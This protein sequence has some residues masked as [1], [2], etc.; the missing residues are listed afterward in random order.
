MVRKAKKNESLLALDE[1]TYTFSGE[2]LVIADESL[3][4]AV[5]GVIGGEESAV[6][7]H[8]TAIVFECANF[9]NISVRK[10]ARA[11]SLQ[12]D[13]SSLFEKGLHPVAT[14]LA[15]LR[16]IE[17]ARELAGGKVASEI[18]DQQHFTFEPTVIRLDVE[19]VSE[20]LGERVTKDVVVRSLRGLGFEVEGEEL[21]LDV[22]VPWWRAQDV[23]IGQDLIEE[24]ARL[25]GYANLP[26]VLPVGSIPTP[27]L[28]RTLAW[29]DRVKDL[30]LA[31]GGTELYSYSL[32]SSKLL[33]A[34][35]FDSKQCL[36]VANPLSEE[37]QYL[38]PTLL[39]SLL[40]AVGGNQRF[41]PHQQLFELSNV[42][43]PLHDRQ[44]PEERP[45]LTV[46]IAGEAEESFFKAKG[47]AETLLQR[48]GISEVKFTPSKTHCPVWE[49]AVSLDMYVGQDFLGT[50][51]VVST[52]TRSAFGLDRA[53]AMVDIN[54]PQLVKHARSV[55]SYAPIPEFPAV[56]R[57]IAI[58]IDKNV[59]WEEIQNVIVSQAEKQ[60]GISVQL[61]FLSA[62]ADT[63]LG[64]NKKSYAF[65]VT[66]QPAQRTLTSAEIEQIIGK[67]TDALQKK[68][69]A[70]PR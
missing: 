37:Y 27:P 41:F 29:E 3:P 47:V 21:E 48:C 52:A 53:V 22:R 35:G 25:Y 69:N 32:V 51:G 13:S 61:V 60:S 38:R 54:F 17:L 64:E 26:S 10:T 50:V 43:L 45:M 16:A 20:W 8:T 40:Q 68:F 1:Q 46:A 70:V 7:N 56:Q 33:E 62:F 42:Y 44:L 5:A 36:A 2:Q 11:L 14:Q 9:N 18:I 19:Q 4:I 34:A 57:D 49:P 12:T 63:A 65:R 66:L 31:L 55:G 67:L 6:S 39:P 23:T 24:V 28:Q 30:L 58:V 59:R 15:L